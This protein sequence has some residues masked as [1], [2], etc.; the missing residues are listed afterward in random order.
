MD[1]LLR[2]VS[3]LTKMTSS[4][5]SA[6]ETANS[7]RFS[8]ANL[9]TAQIEMKRSLGNLGSGLKRL[10]VRASTRRRLSN[11]TSTPFILPTLKPTTESNSANSMNIQSAINLTV[12]PD[13]LLCSS[14]ETLFGKQISINI[15]NS[16]LTVSVYL[17]SMK[18]FKNLQILVC[19]YSMNFS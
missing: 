14:V 17:H 5:S 12:Q 8:L 18:K 7:R 10:S 13:P 4:S 1:V 15:H 6:A 16:N 9:V 2:P 11:T 19:F 3:D